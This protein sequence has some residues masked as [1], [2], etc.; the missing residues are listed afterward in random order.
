MGEGG[1][2][3]RV[4]ASHLAHLIV[5]SGLTVVPL[6][7]CLPLRLP[8]GLSL[9][10]VP[11]VSV[12]VGVRVLRLLHLGASMLLRSSPLQSTC[13]KKGCYWSFLIIRLEDQ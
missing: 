4:S 9:A 13:Q 5:L 7:L 12:L 6:G 1:A 11:A 3:C 10:T 8:L 2:E